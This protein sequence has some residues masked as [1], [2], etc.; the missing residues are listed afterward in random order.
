MKILVLSSHTPSLFWFRMD[1]MVSFQER[2]HS[3]IAVAQDT[4]QKWNDKF[5][6]YGIK[7]RH[8]Y[9][10]RNGTNPFS[11][12]KTFKELD[13]LLKEEKPDKIFVYQAKTII[14]GA[15]AASKN[16]IKDVYPL[17]AGLG[18]IFRGDG[19]KN[20]ILKRIL[21]FQYK[22]AFKKSRKVI[23]QNSDDINTF[24]NRN[25]LKKSQIERIN[26]SGVNLEKFQSVPIPNSPTF[27]YIGRLIRDKGIIEY[28][29]ACKLLKKKHSNI[30]CLLV[31][32]FDT[33]P[34]SIKPEEL[35]I[36]TDNSI[37]QYYGEQKDVRPFIAMCSTY[38]L[39]SY[40]EGTPKSVL[41]AMAAGRA[42]I[43]TDAPGC[44]ETVEDGVNGFLVE[45][46]N[47]NQ[48]IEKMEFLIL[49]PEI[50]NKMGQESLRIVKDKYDVKKVNSEIIQIMGL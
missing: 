11:D 26:G 18:S 22:I 12:F 36:Y 17:M 48:L 28:L 2:G 21:E 6:E 1:M 13:Q 32:P 19:L 40:H 37:I 49:N 9:V 42:I 29:E 41:E 34:S 35:K 33:N 44:R 31:G 43:T 24:L 16:N 50:N 10:K 39:P 27:L 4:E 23:F 38:V 20:K 30:R 15:L 47:V 14:Y 8:V 46:K 25:L 7:Y 5:L 45:V 3:I